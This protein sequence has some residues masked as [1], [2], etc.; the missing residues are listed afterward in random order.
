MKI[1]T[2]LINLDGSDDRLTTASQQLDLQGIKFTRF[3][4][5]DA[6]NKSLDQ[7][8]NYNDIKANKVMGRSLLNG[9]IGCYLS[10]L[11]CVEKFLTTDADYLIVLEDDMQ[12]ESDFV[13]AIQKILKYL[14]SDYTNKWNLINIGPKK[15]K[16]Y[17][18][19]Y[20]FE[21]LDLL[22][23]YYFPIRTIG[24]I[25]S[26]QGAKDFY[27]HGQEIYMPIDNYMQ[28]WLSQNGLGLSVW[29]PLVKPSGFESEIDINRSLK[30]TKSF[31]YRLKHQSRMWKDRISA[32]MNLLNSK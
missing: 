16:I 12:L 30:K 27:Q 18:N 13:E 32:M 20:S 10:H 29:P 5:V 2:Y 14:D 17:K 23:A 8:E 11:G 6:R 31:N 26:R 25:W 22:K 4:A 7:F 21:Q 3:S 15:K 24:L 9:E 28:S 19:L 1:Q